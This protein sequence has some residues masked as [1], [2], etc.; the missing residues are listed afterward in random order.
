[1]SK[2]EFAPRNKKSHK[3]KRNF[4]LNGGHSQKHVR[5]QEDLQGRRNNCNKLLKPWPASLDKTNLNTVMEIDGWKRGLT[6]KYKN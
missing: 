3:A 4:E 5:L 2:D 1:M 6:P